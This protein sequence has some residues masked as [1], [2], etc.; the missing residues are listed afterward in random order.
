MDRPEAID[1]LHAPAG[2]DLGAEGPGEVAWAIVAEMLA[3][4][5]GR[6][7]GFLRDRHAPIHEVPR[8]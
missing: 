7:A 3:V 8:E 4:R 6:D 1:R 2:L 5:R